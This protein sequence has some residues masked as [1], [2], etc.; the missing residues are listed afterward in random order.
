MSDTKVNLFLPDEEQSWTQILENMTNVTVL[1][2]VL[3]LI[4][5]FLRR[6]LRDQSIRLAA[7]VQQTEQNNQQLTQIQ[8]HLNIQIDDA[9]TDE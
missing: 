2:G 3:F 5:K 4:M 1:L 7:M 8:A 6:K 9:K